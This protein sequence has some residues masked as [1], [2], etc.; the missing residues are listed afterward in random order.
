MKF[1]R[2]LMIHANTLLW[3]FSLLRNGFPTQRAMNLNSRTNAWRSCFDNDGDPPVWE[4][5]F[6]ESNDTIVTTTIKLFI[7]CMIVWTGCQG[8]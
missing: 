4:A 1:E 7:G 6:N 3:I 8:K 2:V 5:S